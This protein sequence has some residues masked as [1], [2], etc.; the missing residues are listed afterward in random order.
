MYSTC[1][2]CQY[3]R[4]RT[5]QVSVDECPACGLFFSKWKQ[6]QQAQ[7]TIAEQLAAASEQTQAATLW[8]RFFLRQR[9]DIDVGEY[10]CYVAIYL[11][12]AAWGI[13]FIGLDF[14][15]NQIGQS[16]MH[17]INLVFHEAGHVLFSPLG[18][19]MQVLGGSLFQ[20][21]MPLIVMLAFLIKRQEGFGA[22]MALWWAGQSC[23]DLA[24]YIADAQVMRLPL[25]GGGT[26]FDMPGVHDWRNLLGWLGWLEQDQA[27]AGLADLLGAAMVIISLF[28]GALMLRRYY[29]SLLEAKRQSRDSRGASETVDFFD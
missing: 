27:V 12:L 5:D 16:F 11:G 10:F 24:P 3:Q 2:K 22:A 28:W 20:V 15:S 6:H 25:L 1:P 9:S 17:N 23:M 14:A 26:G 18:R 8:T 4:R 7:E 21:L 29:R 19:F 13:Y